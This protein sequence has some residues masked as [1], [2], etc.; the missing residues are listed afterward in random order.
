M[1]RLPG[2]GHSGYHPPACTCVACVAKRTGYRS[3]RRVWRGRDITDDVPPAY[4][5][6]PASVSQFRR[7]RRLGV[8]AIAASLLAGAVVTVLLIYPLLPVSVQ[9]WIVGV[10]GQIAALSDRLFG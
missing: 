8:F 10:Q 3:N 5:D 1:G 6:A 2:T 4:G 7:R 9:V